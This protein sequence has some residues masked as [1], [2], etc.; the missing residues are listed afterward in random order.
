[1][2]KCNRCKKEKDSKL[3]CENNKEYK[4][5]IDCRIVN[6]IQSKNW[7]EKN[8]ETISLYN[9]IYNDKK[10]DKNEVTYVYAKKIDSDDEWLK[11]ETQL[12]AAKKLGIYA[13]N[14]NKVINGSLKT[15]GGYIFKQEKEIY[16]AKEV[17]WE[18]IK[19]EHNIENKCKGKPSKHRILH[20][21]IDGIVGKKCC[22]C[23][24]WNPL[25]EYNFSK[26]HWDNLRNDCKKCLIEWRKENRQILNEK[27]IAY[28]KNRKLTDAEFKLVKTLRSRLGNAIKRQKSNKNNGTIQLLGCSISYLKEFLE[29]KFKEGMNWENHGEWH[30]DHI[31]PCVLFNLLDEEEQKKCF[32]YTNLQPLWAI[33]NLSKGCKY[34]DE[35]I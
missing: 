28:E 17:N 4:I 14:V 20:E 2:N 3:F 8:K 33:E 10:V 15:T 11:F 19:K 5:C 24:A 18:E 34:I 30:I 21:T 16:N 29:G 12:D 7:R 22:K 1:M 31:R 6:R 32:H 26:S 23:K 9:K 35:N 25:T 27:Y 13:S